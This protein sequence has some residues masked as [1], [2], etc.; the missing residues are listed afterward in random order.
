MNSPTTISQILDGLRIA[1]QTNS[2]ARDLYR[3]SGKWSDKQ[4]YWVE[5]LALEALG[6]IPVVR[7]DRSEQLISFDSL[8]AKFKVAR[9]NGLKRPKL[10]FTDA[11]LGTIVLSLAG[12][13]STNP[14]HIYI[15]TNGIYSGKVSPE[16]RFSPSR[17]CSDAVKSYLKTLNGDV[18]AIG[19]Q[20][21]RETGNCC[22]CAREIT[23]DESMSVGY[24]PICA[25]KWQLPWG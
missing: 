18:A 25:S 6:V 8:V 13:N 16:G 4:R 22:F 17:D 24:G 21:G 14:N 10:T 5:K 9:S 1:Q 7:P 11:V 19:A 12:D 3:K 20:Y 2:F 23:T 15:K